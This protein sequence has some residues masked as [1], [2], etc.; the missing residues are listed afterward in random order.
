MEITGVECI[1]LGT[2]PRERR[3]ADQTHEVALIRITADDG[4]LGIG[5]AAVSP[6]VVKAFIDE[7]TSFSWSRGVSDI[8]VGQDPRD[9]RRLW[10]ELCDGTVWSARVGLG[11]IALAGV[12]MALWDLAG[13]T[14][15]VP[16]WQL[17]GAERPAPVVPYLTMYSGPSPLATTIRNTNEL[18]D[19]AREDGFRAAKIEALTDTTAD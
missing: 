13:K 3:A 8:L 9:P 18:V 14:H 11:R 10:D 2:P 17:L 12:D 6:P 4:S 19:H 7:P 5:E 15:G 16:V 1:V